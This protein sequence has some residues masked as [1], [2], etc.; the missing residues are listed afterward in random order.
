MKTKNY[1]TVMKQIQ[2]MKTKWITTIQINPR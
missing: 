2:Q 1:L